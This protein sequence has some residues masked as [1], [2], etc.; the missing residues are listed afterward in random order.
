MCG[1]DAPSDAPQGLSFAL[2]CNAE[3]STQSSRP[4][5]IVPFTF[6]CTQKKVHLRRPLVFLLYTSD[7]S[8]CLLV[9]PRTPHFLCSAPQCPTFAFLFM[10]E[11]S[12]CPQVLPKPSHAPRFPLKTLT[13]EAPAGSW[14]AGTSLCRMLSRKSRSDSA[15]EI[16]TVSCWLGPWP[17][18]V[19][20]AG[21]GLRSSL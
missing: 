21:E 4:L 11:P 8:V 14:A 16:V 13:A 2:W 20:R 3:T 7:S 15:L 9:P 5:R 19:C 1:F 17:Q 6:W 12:V 10:P 18:H